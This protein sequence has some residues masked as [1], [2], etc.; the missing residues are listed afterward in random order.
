[1]IDSLFRIL[2]KDER[3]GKLPISIPTLIFESECIRVFLGFKE[4][5]YQVE[6]FI[7]KFF[8][9]SEFLL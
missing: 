6:I 1:M 7:L 3:H 2:S 8:D 9:L 4:K 5:N